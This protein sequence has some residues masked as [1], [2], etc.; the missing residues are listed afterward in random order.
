MLQL[1]LQ[2]LVFEIL[3]DNSGSM[4]GSKAK[5]AGKALIIFCEALNRLRIP[6]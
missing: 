5:L 3:V 1:Q 4:H 6:F 2:T